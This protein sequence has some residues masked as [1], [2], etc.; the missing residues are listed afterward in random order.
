[1]QAEKKILRIF[2]ILRLQTGIVAC[3]TFLHA[4]RRSKYLWIFKL[5]E[6]H[7][8]LILNVLQLIFKRIPLQQWNKMCNG[9]Q[10]TADAFS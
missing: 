9:I 3:I 6:L 2:A 5:N 7:L 4:W 10:K 8:Q 1:M